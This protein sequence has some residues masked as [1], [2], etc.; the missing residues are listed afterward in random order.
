[1]Q[2]ALKQAEIEF[3]RIAERIEAAVDRGKFDRS[4]AARDSREYEESKKIRGRNLASLSGQLGVILVKSIEDG[5][6]EDG[7]L[8]SLLT[9]FVGASSSR[10]I[11]AGRLV[12]EIILPKREV[13]GGGARESWISRHDPRGYTQSH[14]NFDDADIHPELLAHAA[15]ALSAM[16][17]EPVAR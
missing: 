17:S 6:F 8:R 10:N 14:C 13:D 9:K 4:K 16:L 5:L 1:M 12:T 15:K 7:Y 11:A 3:L 2:D